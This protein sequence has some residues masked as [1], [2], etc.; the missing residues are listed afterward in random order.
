MHINRFGELRS[1]EELSNEEK[2]EML[3]VGKTF[4]I[5]QDTLHKDLPAKLSTSELT[6]RPD[7][8]KMVGDKLFVF[9][10]PHEI[11]GRIDSIHFQY[12]DRVALYM[13]ITAFIHWEVTNGKLDKHYDILAYPDERSSRRGLMDL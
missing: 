8:I 11:E 1:D 10:P 12:N 7:G 13:S 4:T 3:L 9:V 2:A 5:T 6:F